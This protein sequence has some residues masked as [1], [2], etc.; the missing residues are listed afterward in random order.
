[1]RDYEVLF[2][3]RPDLEEDRYGAVVDEVKKFIESN[4]GEVRTVDVWGSR[5]LAYRIRHFT[6]GYYVRLECKA[7]PTLIA[8]LGRFFRLSE[9]IIRFMPTRLDERAARHARETSQEPS[10]KEPAE[11]AEEALSS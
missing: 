8:P 6:E 4:G 11:D 7:P 10:A 1:V 2:V 3:I 5:R 9:D